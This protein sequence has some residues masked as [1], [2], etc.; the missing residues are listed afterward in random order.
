M[1]SLFAFLHHVAAF[2]LVSALAVEFVLLKENLSTTIARR[3][4][5]ADLMFGISA[6][7]VLFVGLLRVFFFEKG[8]AY[9]FTNLPFLAKLALFVAIG[10]LSAGPTKEFLSWR[11]AL[12]KGQAPIAP[13]E[14]IRGL[15][16]VL[17]I[18]MALA[19]ALVL[20]AVLMARG[21]GSIGWPA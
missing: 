13:P 11:S 6:A 2:A 10:V 7:V 8:A 14:K 12:K 21:V 17:H 18:E 3:L 15:R 16:R 1:S 4:L 5:L 20:C 9:Y 19:A